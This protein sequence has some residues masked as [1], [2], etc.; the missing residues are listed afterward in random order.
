[1]NRMFASWLGLALCAAPSAQAGEY[2]QLTLADGRTLTVS[3]EDTLD[4]GLAFAV[5]Q[6]LAVLSFM[7]LVDMVPADELA[8]EQQPDWSVLIAAASG[9]EA[10]LRG[11][12]HAIPHVGI[13]GEPN[14]VVDLADAS[15]DFVASCATDMDCL[16]AATGE[17]SWLWIVTAVPNDVGGVVLSGRVNVG[18]ETTSV[19]VDA[20]SPETLAP[21][22]WSVLGVRPTAPLVAVATTPP[23][24][25][26][27]P[28]RASG[29]SRSWVPI[30]G[31]SAMQAK[32][33]G[34]VKLAIALSV[35]VVVASVGVAGKTSTR[36]GE[37]VAMS[38]GGYW[39]GTALINE[40]IAQRGA[41]A[42][43]LVVAPSLGPDKVGV[44]M[45]WRGKRRR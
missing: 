29:G 38:L 39:I 12:L 33:S 27:R 1:M 11:A 22:V 19:T 28:P 25:D 14:T 16:V 43:D 20:P 44:T 37:F 10:D 41:R 26:P 35:P 45:S 21:A 15:G 24:R 17:A 7:D 32:D 36:P 5:P 4:T 31:Y 6:G 8:F 3:L 30:P 42:S 9:V 18:G 40:A 2:R 13:I 34:G 23:E